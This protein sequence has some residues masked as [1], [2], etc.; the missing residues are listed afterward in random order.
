[1]NTKHL[2]GGV[3]VSSLFFSSCEKKEAEATSA[4]A[5]QTTATVPAKKVA[6]V[7]TTEI[8]KELAGKAHIMKDGEYVETQ[9]KNADYYL[10]YFTASW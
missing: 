9:I 6:A 10:L 2:L 4:P 8:A 5:N 3:L 1:M 7:P